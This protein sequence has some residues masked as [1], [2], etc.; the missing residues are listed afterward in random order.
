MIDRNTK[1]EKDQNLY[2]GAED[3]EDLSNAT[4]FSVLRDSISNILLAEKIHKV[5]FGS[6]D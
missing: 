4:H 2:N 3:M 6:I 5:N 1:V